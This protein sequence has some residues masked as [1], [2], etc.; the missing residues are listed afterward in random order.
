M[1][2]IVTFIVHGQI[3]RKPKL[4]R[5]IHE[6]FGK[7]YDV[8]VKQTSEIHH[9]DV[10]ATL[11]LEEGTDYLIAVGGDGTVNEVVNAY[12]SSKLQKEVPIGII[13]QGRGNDFVK[14]LGVNEN[15]KS[16]FRAIQSNQLK[17][18]DV[19]WMTFFDSDQNTINRYFINISDIGLGGLAVQMIRNSPKYLS[20]NISYA[21][22]I[23]KSLIAY[24][25][26]KV[27]ISTPDWAYSGKVMSVCMANGK[28]FGSGLCIAPEAKLDDGI[29]EMVI[30]GNVG[31][32]DYLKKVP[33]LKKG[34]KIKHPEVL[35][36]KSASCIIQSQIP[37]PIDM[38]GEF[39][40]YTPL[41]MEMIQN[42]IKILV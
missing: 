15:V 12:L 37:M 22:A 10:L 7:D 30:L 17:S 19:G 24:K 1:L 42:R 31:I 5:L 41:T 28:Y 11:A 6:V 38:D 13:P 16:L 29:A 3:S 9:A 33:L 40:G 8:K 35:Y 26:Q 34:I 25:T 21:W 2:P 18:V 4:I 20:P 23:F 27:E 32:L 39:V 14:S 36:K